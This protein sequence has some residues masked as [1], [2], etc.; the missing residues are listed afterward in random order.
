MSTL[1]FNGCKRV[2]PLKKKTSPLIFATASK[3]PWQ[4]SWTDGSEL[5]SKKEKRRK[6]VIP[7]G[8]CVLSGRML[9]MLFF[10]LAELTALLAWV[11]V[12]WAGVGGQGQHHLVARR[13]SHLQR[14]SDS[15][16]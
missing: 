5:L 12:D 2:L 9:F 7:L 3:P 10:S 11:E 1:T 15:W 14:N 13:P 16:R 6:D 4:R 8:K